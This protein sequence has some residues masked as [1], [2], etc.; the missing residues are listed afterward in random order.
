MIDETLTIEH[1]KARFSEWI[2][3]YDPS[4]RCYW[5]LHW[6]YLEIGWCSVKSMLH[7]EAAILGIQRKYPPYVRF[8]EIGTNA[9]FSSHLRPSR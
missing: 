5:L 6:R 8:W 4:A 2:I 1:I 9:H 7:I 3:A